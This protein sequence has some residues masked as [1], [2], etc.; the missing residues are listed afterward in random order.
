MLRHVA[1]PFRPSRSHPGIAGFVSFYTSHAPRIFIVTADSRRSR[2]S[3]PGR[4]P[5]IAT[6]G[7]LIP[8]FALPSRARRRPQCRGSEPCFPAYVVLDIVQCRESFGWRAR[9]ANGG[10]RGDAAPRPV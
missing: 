9:R 5:P 8:P 1:G 3:S 2:R 6:A 10:Q 7:S 4:W